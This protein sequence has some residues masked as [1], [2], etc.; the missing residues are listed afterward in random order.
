MF[1]NMK[2]MIY[3]AITCENYLILPAVQDIVKEQNNTG[4]STATISRKLKKISIFASI[5]ARFG[6]KVCRKLDLI[7]T[8]VDGD[9]QTFTGA[10]MHGLYVDCE[11][12]VV[13]TLVG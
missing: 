1:T 8:S 4:V 10:Y 12:E 5:T 11:Y 3:H 7:L 2:Q 9:K 6:L 13:H